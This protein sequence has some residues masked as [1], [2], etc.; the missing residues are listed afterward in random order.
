M[1][2]GLGKLLKRPRLAGIH[3]TIPYKMMEAV[4][5]QPTEK[6]IEKRAYEIW[7]RSGKPEG[8]EEEFWQLAEQELRNEEKSSPLRTPDSL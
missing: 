4:V 3:P 7:E 8:R 2:A 5:T 6:E 1:V